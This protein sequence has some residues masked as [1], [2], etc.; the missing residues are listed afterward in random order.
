MYIYVYICTYVYKYRNHS[1]QHLAIH[2]HAPAFAH[3]CFSKPCMHTPISICLQCTC[4]HACK[5]KHICAHF[6]FAFI[7]VIPRYVQT[8]FMDTRCV[9]V[10]ND[11]LGRGMYCHMCF[12][13]HDAMYFF[14]ANLRQGTGRVSISWA[15]PHG[16]PK[17]YL[18][19]RTYL[20]SLSIC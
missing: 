9:N 7:Y 6:T 5:Y 17:H 8:T 11:S 4:M 3:A 2:L 19:R 18:T 14:N 13:W 10:S 12:F 16:H 1:L 15:R 20:M